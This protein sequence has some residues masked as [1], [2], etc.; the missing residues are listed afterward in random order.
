MNP[1]TLVYRLF[2]HMMII[3]IEMIC[4][5][6]TLCKN[7]NSCRTLRDKCRNSVKLDEHET[8]VA[9]MIKYKLEQELFL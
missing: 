1:E 3:N 9:N 5:C 2:L 6:C 4:K 7:K 8:I